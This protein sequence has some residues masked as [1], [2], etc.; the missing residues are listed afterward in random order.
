MRRF[1]V[2]ALAASSLSGVALLACRGDSPESTRSTSTQVAPVAI[3]VQ[4]TPRGGQLLREAHKRFH[5]P[6]SKKHKRTPLLTPSAV[7]GFRRDGDAYVAVATAPRGSIVSAHVTLPAFADGEARVNAGEV[8]IAIKPRVGHSA[9]EWAQR[10][11]IHPNVEPGVTLF[12]RI[13]ADG[14]DDLYE[15]EAPRDT[16]RFAYDVTLHNVA[17]LRLVDGNLEM[18]DASGTPRLRAPAPIAI[19]SDGERRAGSIEVHGCKVDRD[20]RGPWGRPVTAPGAASCEVVATIDAQGLSFPALVDP[21]WVGT[22]NMKSSRAFHKLVRIAGGTDTGKVLAVG[23]TGSGPTSTELFDP[24]SSTWAVSSPLPEM[25]GKGVNAVGLSDGKVIV[26]GGFPATTGSAAKSNVYVRST[27]GTWSVGASMSS[28]RAWFAMTPMT[29]DGKESVFVA[30]GMQ[31]A[32]VKN[33]PV[34]TSEYYEP[35]TD[36]WYTAPSMANERSHFGYALLSDGRMMVAGGHGLD[37]GGI[38]GQVTT[39]ELFTP[40]SKTWASAAAMIAERS[41]GTLIPLAGG[42]AVIAGGWN[43]TEYGALRTLEYFNGTIWSSIAGIGMSE[44][45]MFH[46]AAKLADGRVL[47]AAGN[48][49]PDD[50]VSAMTA[51]SSA[52]L[53]DLGSDPKTTAKIVTTAGMATARI[54]PAWVALDSKILVTGGLTTEVDGTETTSSEIYDATIGVGCTTTGGCASG[55]T[56]TE[57][58]CCKSSSCPEGQTCAAP[59]F[60]GVCT[61]PK[62]APCTNNTECGTGYCI[63]GVCCATACA[64]GCE[65]C[66]SPGKVGDCVPAAVGTDPQG[67]CGGDPICGPFCDKFGDCY[68]YALDGTACGGSVT[69]GGTGLFCKKF[70]CDSSWG[71]CRSTTNNC[72]LTCTTTVSCDETTKTCTA[73]ASGIK[74]GQCVIDG[75]CWAYGDLNPTDSCKL[76]DPPVSKTTWS[77]AASCM[78]GG[79]DTGTFEE[80]TGTEEDTGAVEDTGTEEDTGSID[81]ASADAAPSNILPEA[82]TCGCEVPGRSATSPYAAIAIA[83]ALAAVRKKLGPRA[84][85]PRALASGVGARVTAPPKRELTACSRRRPQ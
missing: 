46:A 44:P 2:R 62:G 70:T 50:P 43:D 52:D 42:T 29:I 1:I 49:E 12:R 14:L 83:L 15:V 81:D 71:D 75:Q 85:Q 23:G 67:Y 32:S 10:I 57:G 47:L 38:A 58:V 60:E 7:D 8:A 82:S 6:G 61:R 53:L 55:L 51:T 26:A 33:K 34:K 74:A 37:S 25:L 84:S 21:A 80:D 35:S 73:T 66:N 48:I 69:D 77:T 78:D 45:R 16:L 9:I 30:G 31:L 4:S 20:P 27:T 40:S 79:V 18:L 3:D 28:G 54:A 39:V 68:E 76:C 17:G 36:S 24:T 63:T 19:G 72:G 59:G 11:A 64:G 22:A 5:L 56:C 41:D 13:D 65:T